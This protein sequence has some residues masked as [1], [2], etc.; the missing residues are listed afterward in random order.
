MSR[1]FSVGALLIL[2]WV[3]AA[4][5]GLQGQ[6]E[7]G[8]DSKTWRTSGW[9]AVRAAYRDSQGRPSREVFLLRQGLFPSE[10]TSRI[11]PCFS[12]SFAADDVEESD[13]I[14]RLKPGAQPLHLDFFLEERRSYRSPW[15]AE[16]VWDGRV[17]EEEGR[18]VVG[19]YSSVHCER[20]V[21]E[22]DSSGR[23][24][25][26][27]GAGGADV[28]P[29]LAI[30]AG[31]LVF[32]P[33]RGNLLRRRPGDEGLVQ[34]RVRSF[35]P[36]PVA[37]PGGELLDGFRFELQAAGDGSVLRLFGRRGGER[38][39]IASCNLGRAPDLGQREG[40]RPELSAGCVQ[41]GD[42]PV[43]TLT[44][45]GQ[46][47]EGV[48]GW[49]GGLM[50]RPVSSDTTAPPAV[51]V[52]VEAVAID[53]D[54]GDW[55]NI[56]GTGDPEGD[57][58]SYLYPNPDTDLLE[59][60]VTNDAE[61]LYFYAR[62]AGAFGRTGP[63][64]RYYWYAYLDVDADPGTGYVPTRDDNCYFGVALGD[65]C[66]AQFEFVGGK[67][68]KTFFG[69]TGV[70]TEE[71]VLNGRVKLGPSH[72]APVDAEGRKRDRYKVEYVHRE[73]GRSITHDRKPGTSEDIILAL[74]PD[75]SEMEMRVAMAG[76]LQADSGQPVMAVGQ[77]ID[78]A[79]GVEASSDFYGAK[80]W[81]ADSSAVVYGHVLR[82]AKRKP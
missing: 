38:R 19:G 22:I 75:A 77:R 78:L 24:A 44:W 76:F 60:K 64:G 40:Y 3:L 26:R 66:E 41:A 80:E 51:E 31:E 49:S 20:P 54:F 8:A 73:G 14:Q 82:H 32:D 59:F 7:A 69:F 67:F 17:Y 62:V 16:P 46:F 52:E 21:G 11:S 25:A 9:D 56:A 34:E 58:V 61:H 63:E 23:F 33:F 55:R 70:G 47:A 27:E 65:D 39:E 6:G 45:R 2:G 50:L 12:G 57:H 81:G 13:G 15:K 71:E 35:L 43:T 79:V 68:I 1:R 5:G 42:G 36:V 28:F 72:Y 10:E 29:L 18:L 48:T 53:G 37:G 4:A 74:S 30:P